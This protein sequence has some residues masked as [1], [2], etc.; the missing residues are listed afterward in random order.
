MPG[1]GATGVIAAA[2]VALRIAGHVQPMPA[3]AHAELRRTEQALH[4]PWPSLRCLVA[5]ERLHLGGGRRQPG[6]VV[7]DSADQ[8]LPFGTRRKPEPGLGQALGNKGIDGCPNIESI[9][10][11][12]RVN[13]YRL[14]GPV[15]KLLLGKANGV[16]ILWLGADGLC[17]LRDPV[18]DDLFLIGCQLLGAVRHL[19]RGD[20]LPKQASIGIA[21]YDGCAGVAPG[22][23]QVHQPD[24]ESAAFLFLLAVTMKTGSLE[25]R[26]NVRLK[27]EC[28]GVGGVCAGC[29]EQ[30]GNQAGQV[31][32]SDI[33]PIGQP[34][35][36][37]TGQAN[38][39]RSTGRRAWPSAWF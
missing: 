15:A 22:L 28:L 34:R 11:W 27:P 25:D 3:P 8:R 30:G 32:A 14:K 5:D 33:H 20:L 24:V 4:Q 31:C 35:W 21:G 37:K 36:Y 10:L 26:A 6:E 17:A 9:W 2:A 1:V 19:V 7:G 13:L 29:C 12:Y 39:P 23:H 18:P 38:Q 16:R